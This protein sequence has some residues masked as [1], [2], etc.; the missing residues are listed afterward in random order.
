MIIFAFLWPAFRGAVFLAVGMMLLGAIQHFFFPQVMWLPDAG[1]IALTAAA[2][3]GAGRNRILLDIVY[4]IRSFGILF[5][6]FFA[7]TGSFVGM[8]VHPMVYVLVPAII[9]AQMRISLL[10]R[11]EERALGL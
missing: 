6:A 4:A 11:A 3:I 10:K 9:I 5:A 7:V 2:L 1:F 8:G